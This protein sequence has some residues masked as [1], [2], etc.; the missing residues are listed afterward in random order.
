M[1]S[2]NRDEKIK[3]IRDDLNKESLDD[4]PLFLETLPNGY[5]QHAIS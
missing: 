4:I 5:I 1:M 2:D 3:F